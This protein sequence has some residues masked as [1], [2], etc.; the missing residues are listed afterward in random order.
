MSFSMLNFSIACVAKSTASCCMSSDMSAFLITAFFSDMLA[1]L[2]AHGGEEEEEGKKFATLL[3]E[4]PPQ[5]RLAPP[6]IDRSIVTETRYR[7][8]RQLYIYITESWLGIDV[9]IEI[10]RYRI[11]ADRYTLEIDRYRIETDSYRIEADRFR[12]ESIDKLKDISVK[13]A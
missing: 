7:L 4:A 10:A 1:S 5:V 6:Q 8:E 11:E 3:Q 12:R 9:R 13:P 2:T